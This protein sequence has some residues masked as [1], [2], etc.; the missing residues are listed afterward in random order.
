MRA[1]IYTRISDARDRDT[2]GVRRQEQDCRKLVAER[3]WDVADVYCDNNKSASKGVRPEYRRLLSDVAAGAVDVVV[4]WSTDRL[5]RRLTDLEEI[6]AV[7]GQVPVATV[8]SGTVD[9]ST[10]DG[11]T[12]AR[13]LGS[14]A[15]GEV[16]KR[17]ERV[18]RAARQRAEAGRFNGGTRRF[19]YDK[20]MKELEAVEADAIVWGTDQ[21]L[22]GGSI[23]EVCREWTRRGLTGPSGAA[24]TPNAVRGI[25]L[26][27]VNA[28]LSVYKGKEVGESVAPVIVDREAFHR[29]RAVLS[30]P[31]RRTSPEGE[32]RT[33]LSG[34][35]LCGV[36]GGPVRAHTRKRSKEGPSR[37]SYACKERHVSRSR[38][39]LDEAVSD[40]VIAYLTQNRAL[41]RRA[42]ATVSRTAQ[43]A[44]SDAA[45]LQQRLDQLAE[46]VSA[47]EL[48]PA[49]FAAAAKGVRER[50]AE[51]ESRVTRH[52]G[53]PATS[54]LL[55]GSDVA[56]AWAA[57]SPV[58]RRAVIRE[59]IESITL[60][61]GTP[62]R[63]NMDGTMV[64]WRRRG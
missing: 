47:G 7:L 22:A 53:A 58:T 40:L 6:V 54:S 8:R 15:Q 20:T 21:L 56:S 38:G 57:A 55:S 45:A 5:Y 3:A 43:R 24:L 44:A 14:V 31:R 11:K 49:D 28:G 18:A 35:L 9:L 17:G 63:F 64:V 1:A 34:V 62:G 36:C 25:L 50:L 10:A 61:V 37:P 32:H 27:P 48:D 52:G 60:P 30:D 39:K 2:A 16:E 46:L 13:I 29:L 42:P 26:R 4:T 51:A 19:G 23:R 33:M 12:V 41:L 59:I